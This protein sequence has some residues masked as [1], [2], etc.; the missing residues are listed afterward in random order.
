M[1]CKVF[2]IDNLG[3]ITVYKRRGVKRL[4]LKIVNGQIKVTQPTWLPYAT[5]IKFAKDSKSW[6]DEQTMKFAPSLLTDKHNIGKS[7]T[8]NYLP[9]ERLRT[10]T[11]QGV[12]NIY[13]P[14]HLHIKHPDVQKASITAA[15][16]ALKKEAD[17][18]LPGRLD[19]TANQ[20]NFIYH[21]VKTKS[22]KSRWGSCTNQKVITLNI[23]LMM[24]PQ[25]LIDYVILHELTHTKYLNHSQQFWAAIEDIMPDYKTRK[26]LLKQHQQTALII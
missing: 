11:S 18:E 16:R 4:N 8:L 25:G 13:V 10:K 6:I 5:S 17:Q 15:K 12:I 22:M 19:H 1:A 26:K 20:H 21:S 2:N 9:G 3:Q 7:H 14:P 24:L 23:Y